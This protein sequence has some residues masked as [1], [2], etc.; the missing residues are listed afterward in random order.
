M[1]PITWRKKGLV[2]DEIGLALHVRSHAAPGQELASLQMYL[3]SRGT[4]ALSNSKAA[5]VLAV[6][7]QGS[8]WWAPRSVTEPGQ[9]LAESR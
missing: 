8:S 9:P 7:H 4:C 2:K 5:L 1:R 6:Q 3:S